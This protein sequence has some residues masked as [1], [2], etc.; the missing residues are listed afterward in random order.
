MRKHPS[1]TIS[2]SIAGILLTTVFVCGSTAW[3]AENRNA[4][5]NEATP[6]PSQASAQPPLGNPPAAPAAKA[7]PVKEPGAALLNAV[8][9]RLSHAGR[10]QEGIKVHGHWTIE[11]R[12]PDGSLASHR[13]FENSLVP[14]QNNGGVLLS[15]AL[16]RQ[17]NVGVW[18]VKL[19]SSTAP[20]AGS[21]A[22]IIDEPNSPIAGIPVECLTLC[23]NSTNLTLT[24]GGFTSN[25]YS[26]ATFTL[27]GSGTVPQGFGPAIGFVTTYNVPCLPGVTP[28]PPACLAVQQSGGI[29]I[30]LSASSLENLFVA[31]TGA[32]LDGVGNDPAAVPVSAGQTV[33][34]TVNISFS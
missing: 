17:A 29:N 23:S 24:G 14:G 25:V 1:P 26:G 19:E 9:K 2:R 5:N 12:N 21:N 15:M 34:V 10:E 30:N 16:A 28:T 33:A 31:F 7:Q 8:P 11:V 13:E 22:L 18:E 32:T 20:N 27:A 4:N 6:V 3:A